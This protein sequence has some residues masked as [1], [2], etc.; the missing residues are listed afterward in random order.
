MKVTTSSHT[1][2]VL[3]ALPVL[4]VLG[5]TRFA[6]ACV[7]GTGTSASCSE[8][9]L[10]DCL[11][12]GIDFDGTVTF[13]CGG[14]ATITATTTKTINADTTIDASGSIGT[15]II[16]GGGPAGLFF[17]IAPF[18]VK[19]V[20][21]DGNG[22]DG[23]IAQ[24]PSFPS[25]V[26]VT[27]AA[28]TNN[29]IGI[30]LFGMLTV[31]NSTLSQN[32]VVGITTISATVI[33]DNGNFFQNGTAI[34]SGGTVTVTNSTFGGNHGASGSG[35]NGP[36][37]NSGGSLTVVS[38]TFS[39]NTATNNGGAIYATG[40][41]TVSNSTFVGNTTGTSGAG[42]AIDVAGSG[43]LEVINCTLSGNGAHAGAAIANNTSGAVTVV[44]SI[45][46]HP[47]ISLNLPGG[48]CSGTIT[49]DGHNIDDGTTCGF[50][51]SG[52]AT[53]TGTS[54]CSTN[55]Q[56]GPLQNNGG[57]TQTIA[58]AS[59]SPAIDAGD[60]SVCAAAPVNGLDQRGFARPGSG[61]TNCSIGAYE[62]QATS[63][64]LDV[65]RN[66]VDDV[67]TDVVYINRRL[68]LLTPVPPS[69][70]VIDPSIPPDATITI[71]IDAIRSSLD[72]DANGI[73]DAATDLVYITR[74]LL[75]LTPVP[76][77]FRLLDPT[78]PSD[79]VIAQRIDALCPR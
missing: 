52:C 47:L 79:A 41:T 53:T 3:L 38:S 71:N 23:A 64:L 37:I 8:A 72:V 43:S 32:T 76:P 7:V 19:N 78:I 69:F 30:D 73:V 22:G 20:D 39:S 55:P 25:P 35:G 33:V 61:A 60:E 5:A 45:L 68:L 21:L 50:T 74:R 66:G 26:T 57:P 9:A 48:N 18:T 70:R 11:P 67:S 36:A 46:A 58:L 54:F 4:A 75:Q 51:G 16:S 24:S 29:V 17:A 59:A 49:D 27:N 15:I 10:D 44:N 65:D 31:T 13:S 6:L 2:F 1:R 12:G 14:N 56:V 28:I 63:C 40:T 77:R 34:T 62:F 42:G